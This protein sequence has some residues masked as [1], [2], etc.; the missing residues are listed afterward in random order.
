MS[1]APLR[2]VRRLL[3][4]VRV[5]LVPLLKFSLDTSQHCAHSRSNNVDSGLDYHSHLITIFEGEPK[6][7]KPREIGVMAR[8]SA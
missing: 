8:P 7:T 3:G 5:K 6:I 2:S 4:S 1:I